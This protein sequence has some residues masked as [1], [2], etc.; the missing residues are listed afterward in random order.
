M[1]FKILIS[2]ILLPTKIFC[3]EMITYK[4][5]KPIFETVKNDNEKKLIILLDYGVKINEKDL[6]GQNALTVAIK[7]LD[8]LKIAKILIAHK[9]NINSQD[10]EGNT[11]LMHA[12]RLA[13][14]SKFIL[15]LRNHA[16]IDIKNN[17]GQD[18]ES[19]AQTIL[20]NTLEKNL[21]KI[22]IIIDILKN[23]K[24]KIMERA[25]ISKQG[26]CIIM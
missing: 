1:N 26:S 10:F 17:N 5:E 16:K 15:L 2:I 23:H 13:N 3:F 9:I 11:A 24:K 18:A 8:N 25:E 4:Q 19:Y 22:K 20:L 6:L 14:I 12:I 21:I 7:K